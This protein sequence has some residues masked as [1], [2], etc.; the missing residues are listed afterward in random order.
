MSLSSCTDKLWK[1]LHIDTMNMYSMQKVIQNKQTKKLNKKNL[2]FFFL[3][4]LT[5]KFDIF[6]FIFTSYECK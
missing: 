1:K 2:E 4:L 5:Y 3:Y 6:T